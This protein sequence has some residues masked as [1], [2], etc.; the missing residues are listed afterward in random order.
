MPSSRRSKRCTR[1]TAKSLH[2]YDSWRPS[3]LGQRVKTPPCSQLVQPPAE[4]P[5]Q[6]V[7]IFFSPTGQREAKATP[8][9]RP[10]RQQG[11]LPGKPRASGGMA[12]AHGSGPCVR[13]DVRVQLPPRPLGRGPPGSCFAGRA[14]SYIYTGAEPP[15]APT[16]RWALFVLLL[17]SRA[18]PACS[19]TSLWGASLLPSVSPWLPAASPSFWLVPGRRFTS[20]FLRGR[21][22]RLGLFVLRA[23]GPRSSGA[24]FLALWHFFL[25]LVFC[26][27]CWSGSCVFWVAM[28]P[29]SAH[30]PVT[31]RNLGCFARGVAKV[32][33]P[34]RCWVFVGLGRLM[35]AVWGVW[36][37]G[38]GFSFSGQRTGFSFAIGCTVSV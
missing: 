10:G 4:P 8:V 6:P 21:F 20:S 25:F 9:P 31:S 37:F 35:R 7:L 27:S 2:A 33:F 30:G 29:Q 26:C 16:V 34:G 11:K 22:L 13:K 15:V 17:T 23:L 38:T 32:A 36:G 24:W 28:A 3:Y 1:P 18:S 14:S 19:A 5:R 12:D